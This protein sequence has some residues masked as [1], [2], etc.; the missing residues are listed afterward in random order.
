MIVSDED[1]SEREGLYVCSSSDRQEG[2][3][4]VIGFVT[5]AHSFVF[6]PFRNWEL[7]KLLRSA[8]DVVP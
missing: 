7:V 4:P 3:E 6:D 5:H 1:R 8:G 2:T